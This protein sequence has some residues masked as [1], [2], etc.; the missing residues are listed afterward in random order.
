MCESKSIS[1]ADDNRDPPISCCRCWFWGV[2]GGGGGSIP[3]KS[4]I[5]DG[6]FIRCCCGIGEQ[7]DIIE[8]CKRGW[9]AGRLVSGTVET[10]VAVK[11]PLFEGNPM[12]GRIGV[13]IG[14]IDGAT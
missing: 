6:L 3:D 5:V 10:G 4:N 11:D 14:G 1:S 12:D 2:G 8:C 13:W 7:S 9:L